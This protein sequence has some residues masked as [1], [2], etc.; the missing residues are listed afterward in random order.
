MNLGSA[1]L[2][3]AGLETD[4]R[5]TNIDI[6]NT[7]KETEVTQGLSYGQSVGAVGPYP[8]SANVGVS[9]EIR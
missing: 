2:V 8:V 9:R 1:S 5:G 3:S 6:V 7:F 4:N